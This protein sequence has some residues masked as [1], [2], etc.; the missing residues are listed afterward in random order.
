MRR[1]TR[2]TNA[3][4]KK[5]ENHTAHEW[6][7]YTVVHYNFI[8][9]CTSACA[10]TYPRHGGGRSSK[11]LWGRGRILGNDHDVEASP[12]PKRPASID[13]TRVPFQSD[14]TTQTGD[15]FQLVSGGANSF[16]STICGPL[17]NKGRR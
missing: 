3:F 6:R 9:M 16:G 4:S 14:D 15:G 11:T 7:V 17:V 1:F 5:I 13:R 10:C 2:L 12:K 8:R